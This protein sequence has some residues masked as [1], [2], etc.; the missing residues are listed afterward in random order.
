VDT[1]KKAALDQLKLLI[2]TR[3]A[4]HFDTRELENQYLS[5]QPKVDQAA[6]NTSL[7]A[8]KDKIAAK[9]QPAQPQQQY[10]P[11]WQP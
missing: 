9:T 10:K 8:A 11:F 2:Q 4:G 3:R 6:V 5:L 1:L 7:A